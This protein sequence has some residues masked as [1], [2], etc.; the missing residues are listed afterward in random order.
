MSRSQLR[1]EFIQIP[2]REQ[3]L[4]AI[5]RQDASYVR[6]V[7][8]VQER[9]GWTKNLSKYLRDLLLEWR[10]PASSSSTSSSGRSES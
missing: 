8:Q 7:L 5:K 6:G 4:D 1:R 9:K 2:N 10:S 3:L